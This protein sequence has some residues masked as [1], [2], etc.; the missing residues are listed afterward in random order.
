MLEPRPMVWNSHQ[1]RSTRLR[2]DLLHG[3]CARHREEPHCLRLFGISRVLS[4][5]AH[6][7]QWCRYRGATLQTLESLRRIKQ[8][9]Q[10]PRNGR[11]AVTGVRILYVWLPSRHNMSYSA[12]QIG[13]TVSFNAFSDVLSAPTPTPCKMLFSMRSSLAATRCRGPAVVLAITAASS[14]TVV[15]YLDRRMDT[16]DYSACR[17]PL[18]IRSRSEET[19]GR[20]ESHALHSLLTDLAKASSWGSREV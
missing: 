15:L 20:N 17:K 2:K 3:S 1:L 5:S 10:L 9:L 11:D 14:S 13:P 8:P 18:R 7:Q 16:L 4:N 19:V 12:C 6:C